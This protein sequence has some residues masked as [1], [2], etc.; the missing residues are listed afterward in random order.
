VPVRH[1][2]V[3]IFA[4]G[5]ALLP[6]GEAAAAPRVVASI[7]PVHAL[8]AG[9]ME[10]IGTPTLLVPPGASPHGYQM[11]PS[12]A[13][14]LAEADL[15]VWIG[16]PLETFLVKPIASLAGAAASLE[17]LEAPG[18]TLL[19][20]REGGLP[21]AHA[22]EG[23]H[24]HDGMDPHVWLDPGN[25]RA[26]AAAIA[27]AL[28]KRDPGNAAAYAAN[29]GRLDRRLAA[30]AEELRKALAPVRTRPFIVLH[31]AFQYLERAFGLAVVGSI[32]VSPD[33][34]P[35]A[36]RLAELRA[37]LLGHGVVCV[38]GEPQT[39]TGHV[40]TLVESTDIE[41]GELDAEG[42][43]EI[44]PGPDAYFALMRANARAL[45]ACLSRSG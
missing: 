25:A 4:L 6:W 39:R 36:R 26:I 34:P 44:T 24:D 43:P 3:P 18:L 1:L 21:E 33:R 32:T 10:G 35:S 15:V 7:L 28:A 41:T 27:R 42:G 40:A 17:L 14:A 11:R 16:E 5:L 20:A 2:T 9:V 12:E 30:L 45:V 29:A 13:A 31:D 19:P 23:E 38:F 37:A 8:T 22:D